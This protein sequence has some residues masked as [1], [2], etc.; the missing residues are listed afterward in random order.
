MPGVYASSYGLM[1]LM[2]MPIP[3]AQFTVLPAIVMLVAFFFAALGEELGWSGYVIDPMQER[4]GALGAAI[5]LGLVWAAWHIVPLVQAHR[6]PTWIAWW[7][8]FTVTFRVLIVWL[9]NN[10]GKSVSAAAMFHD[11][12]NVSWQLFPIH[13]SYYDPRVTSLI[14]TFAAIVITAIWG[15]RAL[16]RHRNP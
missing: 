1:R 15:P 12:N 9:F 4:W 5:L 6:S 3:T 14:V 8:L 16:A 13:G 7:C 10:T 2:G 11:T